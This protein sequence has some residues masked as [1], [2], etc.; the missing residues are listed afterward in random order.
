MG[1]GGRGGD[2][3]GDGFRQPLWG[4]NSGGRVSGFLKKASGRCRET[5]TTEGGGAVV[6]VVSKELSSVGR[7]GPR[8][9]LAPMVVCCARKVGVRPCPWGSLPLEG[10]GGA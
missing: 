3:P 7:Q 8:A 10:E 9:E 4:L 5:L 2:M 6:E 1:G